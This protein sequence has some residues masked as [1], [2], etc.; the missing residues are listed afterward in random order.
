MRLTEDDL[1]RGHREAIWQV[2]AR[3]DNADMQVAVARE[4]CHPYRL[5]LDLSVPEGIR[6][7]G[8]A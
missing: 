6:E 3:I 4:W 2:R 8:A 5:P 1:C 7:L